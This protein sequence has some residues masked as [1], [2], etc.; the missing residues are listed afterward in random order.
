MAADKI[1]RMPRAPVLPSVLTGAKNVDTPAAPGDALGPGAQADTDVPSELRLARSAAARLA[2]AHQDYLRHSTFLHQQFLAL[3]QKTQVPAFPALPS[4]VPQVDAAAPPL[5]PMRPKGP[6]LGRRE[7]EIH[8]AGKIS[9]IFGPLFE[10]Q[11]RHRHQLRIAKPPLLFVDRIIG[12]S[13]TPAAMGPGTILSETDV[14]PSSW[15]LDAFGRMPPSVM[16]EAGQ[17]NIVLMS[18]LGIDLQHEGDRVYRLISSDTR[19]LGSPPRAGETLSY[20]IS[21]DG[22]AKLGDIQL[23]TLNVIASAG[24]TVR[25]TARMQAGL[26]SAADLANATSLTWDAATDRRKLEG[27]LDTP[28]RRSSHSAFSHAQVTAFIEGRPFDCFGT[29]FERTQAHVR[30]PTISGGRLRAIDEVEVL[31]PAGGPWQRGYLR[32]ITAIP[33]NAWFFAAHFHDDPCMPGFLMLEGVFQCLAFYLAALGFTID[34]DGWRFDVVPG[35][36]YNLRWRGQVSPGHRLLTYELFVESLS[37]SP[38]PTLLADVVMSVDGKRV[39]W[40][41]RMRV[42]LTP[43]VPLDAF[44]Q[45]GPVSHKLTGDPVPLARL[46]GLL[47]HSDPRP[48]AKLGEHPLGYAA[49]LAMAWGWPS[50]AFGPTYRPLDGMRVTRLPGPPLLLVSRITELAA[51]V[52]VRRSGSELTAAYDVPA[53]IWYFEQ[54][55]T[56]AM[57]FVAFLEMLL[58]PCGI[59]SWITDVDPQASYDQ[60]RVYRNLDGTL[61]VHAAVTPQLGALKTRVQLISAPLMSNLRLFKF[62]IECRLGDRLIAQAQSD[63]GF[64]P[65]ETMAAQSGLPTPQEERDRLRTPS[66]YLVDLTERPAKYFAGSLRLPGPMLCMLKRVTGFWPKGGSAGLGYLRGEKTLHPGDWYFQAHFF[67]DPVQPGSLGLE[68]LCQLL[69]FYMIEVGLGAGIAGAR[70]ECPM[71]ARPVTWK[72]RGQIV[73]ENQRVE[74]ELEIT[75][76]GHDERGPFAVAQGWLWVDGMRVYHVK[77][78]GIQILSN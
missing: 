43:D 78:L 21:T 59:L 71:R 25:A 41:R 10:R 65:P 4:P 33:A 36:D 2:L 11:D 49:V 5:A 76:L 77:N 51:T 8:G 7:L 50:D 52:G 73:P 18:Y 58:Q 72:Y 66:E 48:P 13:G 57:P 30:P 3:R 12:I 31:D 68:G 40:V 24:G 55:G 54:N 70:F 19:V 14:L 37:A 22:H 64:F 75:E 26:F 34:R 27:P 38:E 20:E 32:A 56:A 74:Y 35:S 69:Q 46:G 62:A 28:V 29:G 47:G 61:T 23:F 39:F 53:D 16:V 45:S 63:F 60:N 44:R 1:Q 67:E 9:S 15:Y 42:R 17:A 6:K